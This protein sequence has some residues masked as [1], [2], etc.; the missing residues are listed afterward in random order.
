MTFTKLKYRFQYRYNTDGSG[1]AKGALTV[2]HL[3]CTFDPSESWNRRPTDARLLSHEQGHFDI[4]ELTRRKIWAFW[5]NDLSRRTWEFGSV[6]ELRNGIHQRVEQTLAP[7]FERMTL[8]HK[9]YDQETNHGRNHEAQDQWRRRLDAELALM[10]K[11]A[12][13]NAGGDAG[14]KPGA[15]GGGDAQG[16]SRR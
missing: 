13:G 2:F 10:P 11:A 4:A 5:Q 12:G 14:T 15:N 7:Y 6:D 8:L 16:A 3:D 1:A 9:Q